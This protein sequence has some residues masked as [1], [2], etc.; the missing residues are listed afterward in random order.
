[1]TC[2]HLRIPFLLFFV[3]IE[4]AVYKSCENSMLLFINGSIFDIMNIQNNQFLECEWKPMLTPLRSVT[5]RSFSWLRNIFLKSFQDWL[6]SVQQRQGNFTKDSGLKIIISWQTHEG[7]KLSVNSIIEATQFLL[8]HQVKYALT[9]RFCKS[10]LENWFGRQRSLESRKDNPS[11]ADFGSN[12]NAIRNQKNS[13]QSLIV[14][15]LIV[16]WLP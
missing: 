6:N 12:N 5:R 16:S 8:W 15:L 3:K 2:S 14:M 9:E 11:M 10:P 1:M 7:L 4:N 13:N